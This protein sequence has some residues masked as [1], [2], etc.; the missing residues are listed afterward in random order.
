VAD[1]VFVCILRTIAF[2]AVFLM[3]HDDPARALGLD[4][5]T[6]MAFTS[7]TAAAAWQSAEA[8]QRSTIR[9]GE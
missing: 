1:I 3:I 9:K 6:W 5:S 7:C 8:V 2:M 4:G